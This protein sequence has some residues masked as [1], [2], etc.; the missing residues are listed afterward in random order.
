MM[1][2]AVQDITTVKTMSQVEFLRPIK[3]SQTPFL[4]HPSDI[5]VSPIRRQNPPALHLTPAK[6]PKKRRGQSRTP[7]QLAD[8]CLS[9]PLHA[10]P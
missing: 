2:G 5:G 8:P 1:R 7:R 6:A 10:R 4:R 3:W 9:A